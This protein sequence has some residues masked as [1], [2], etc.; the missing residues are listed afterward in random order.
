MLA[1][2]RR[3]FAL[4][5]FTYAGVYSLYAGSIIINEIH[6]NPDVK[7]DLVKF[8]ELYNRGSNTVDLSNW[9]FASGVDFTFPAGTVLAP[10]KYLVVAE[11]P[12]V[13]KAKFGATAL[14]PWI[15]NL[16]GQGER[17]TL[18]N[19]NGEVEDSVEYQNGF[20]WPTVGDAPSSSIELVNPEFDNDLGGNWRSSLSSSGGPPGE[21]IVPIEQEWRYE[22]SGTDPGST[23]KDGSFDDSTWPSGKALLYHETAALP[24]PKNTPLNLGNSAY[25]FRT[26]FNFAGDPSQA[27]LE[28][29]TVIDDGGAIYL[30]GQEVYRL[31]LP[32]GADYSTYATRTVGDAAYEGPFPISSAALKQG[33]NVL[34]VEVHQANASS[35]DVVFGLTLTAKSGTVVT[36]NGPTPGIRNSVFAANLAPLIRQVEHSPGQ[37]ASGQEVR[38]TAKITD[39]DGVKDVTLQY[40]LVDPGSYIELTDPAYAT[41]W[42]SVSMKDDGLNGD[43]K[44]GDDIYTIALPASLQT[45]RRLVRYRIKATDNGARALTVPYADDPQPNFAYF[46]YDGIPPYKG[47]IQPG[48]ADAIRGKVV[49]YPTNVMQTMPAYHLISKNDS[50]MHCQFIDQYGGQEYLW[51]GTMVYDGKVYD[52]IHYRARGGVWRYSM[53]KNAWKIKFNRGHYFEARDNY[54]NKYAAPWPRLNFRPGIQQGDYQHRGEQG[55]FEAVNY[56]MFNLAGVEACNTQFFQLRVVDDASESGATQYDGDFWG[57]YLGVEEGD[58]AFI[59]DHNLPDGNY[60]M[61]RNGSGTIQNQGR[62]EAPDGS[63]LANFLN[64]FRSTTPTDQW[65][66]DNLDLERYFTYRT[67]I[68]CTHHYDIDDPPGK[69]YFFFHNP[70]TGRW[71]VHPWDMDLTWANNMYGGGVEPFKNRVLPRAMFSTEYQNRGRELRDLLFNPDQAGQLIDELARFIYKPEMGATLVGADRAQWDYNPI[72]ASGYVLSSK[73]GQGLF[74]KFPL[75]SV[76]RDFTGALQ[77][78]KN[79]VVSR[80]QWFDQNILKATGLPGAPVVTLTG[81]AS[82]PVNRLTFQSSSYTGTAPFSAMKWRIAEVSDPTAP[83]YDPATPK[84]YEI[85]AAWESAETPAFQADMT[86]PSTAVK[87]GHAYRVRARFKDNTGKWGH[88][89]APVQFIAGE[90][91]NAA[92]LVDHLRVSELMYNPPA[93][94]DLEFVELHNESTDLPLDLGGI[95]FTEGVDYTVPIGVTLA[96]GGYLLVVRAD[97]ANGFQGFRDYYKLDSSVAIVGP[98]AGALDN[99]GE[100]ITLRTAANGTVI[101]S[102]TYGDARGWPEAADGAGHSLVPRSLS[103]EAIVQGS[104]DYGRNWNASAYINGSPGAPDPVRADPIVLNE[105]LANTDALPTGPNDWVELYNRSDLT[106]TF[107]EN[108]YLSDDL[109]HLKKWMIPAGTTIPA[110]Q[111]A[112]FDEKTGFHQDTNGFGISKEG[113]TL[114]L[115][116]LPGNEQDHVSDAVSFKGQEPNFSWGRYPDGGVEWMVS[117]PTPLAANASSPAHVVITELMF[118]PK[119]VTGS[120][121]E[122]ATNEFVEITNPTSAEVALS[123]A[124]GPWRIDGGIKFTFPPN[125]KLSSGASLLLVNFD[126]ADTATLFGFKAA[127]S[128]GDALILGPY[129]G[130][131]ANSS[132]RI[133][134]EKHLPPDPITGQ[135]SWAIVDEVIYSNLAPWPVSANGSGSSLQRLDSGVAGNAPGNWTVASPTPGSYAVVLASDRDKDG[136]PD[137]WEVAH[138]LD[139]AN[140]ND[141]ALDSDGDGL[142]NLQEFLSGT[143]PQDNTDALR[144]Q[145]M[146]EAGQLKLH[147]TAQPGHTY[148]VLRAPAASSQN[149][150]VVEQVSAQASPTPIAVPITLPQGT[151]LQ[152]FRVITPALP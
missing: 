148:S 142:S 12:S 65:W 138:H 33:D 67:I 140:P 118:Q 69:N 54:G 99:N 60:Y 27:A 68:E 11:N 59:S 42:T 16:S 6:H 66:R 14:G 131:L 102:A 135:T 22:Q 101:F 9:R 38:I 115:S 61:M 110:H 34:A 37:P 144:L 8:I 17:I 133:A 129:G 13:L 107:P 71:S 80:G 56:A 139:P 89:S 78:M 104:L 141:A 134:L 36:G 92:A 106:F 146:A 18:R 52:H 35:S 31:F 62:L 117:S 152:F 137:D 149:W 41:S 19:A 100:R 1:L 83:A 4:A 58:S 97:P 86:I 93:G 145:A 57:L 132:D 3:L 49:T 70:E 121:I 64:T 46:V 119:A 26:H 122:N 125:V 44:A 116:F 111:W 25:Y 2:I 24:A 23:W 40:Q 109:A 47:A 126:P 79:Y 28:I 10:D 29:K 128:I 81:P 105:V 20:P 82:H 91:D 15:G 123:E 74:Y 85:T 84:K 120:M 147:F 43:E 95:K 88:W 90:P 53:G 87:V 136:L 51:S 113:E 127:Y 32:A 143:D 7:T 72:M 76:S 96:P 151:T 48:S 112:R 108:W 55:M 45:N 5:L 63:D 98:Y 73:A 75:E 103:V 21:T 130:K 114:L 124:G 150:S 77:L 50:I 39:S 94:S 30:N